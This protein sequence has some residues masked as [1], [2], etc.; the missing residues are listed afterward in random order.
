MALRPA[1]LAV[2]VAAALAPAS[3]VASCNPGTADDPWPNCPGHVGGSEAHADRIPVLHLGVTTEYA[4]YRTHKSICSSV[5]AYQVGHHVAQGALPPAH[6]YYAW[7]VRAQ[8]I[9]VCGRHF[10]VHGHSAGPDRS[11]GESIR[12]PSLPGNRTTPVD[13]GWWVSEQRSYAQLHGS[14]GH[15]QDGFWHYRLYNP[16]AGTVTVQLYGICRVV[17]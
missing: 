7:S 13:V 16:G 12:C 9:L 3:A 10:E 14:F 4:G 1:L 15:N 2:L 11:Q 17:V 8:G 5:G 6:Y